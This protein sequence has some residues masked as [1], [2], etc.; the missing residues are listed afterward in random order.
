VRSWVIAEPLEA[1]M[2]DW[3]AFLVGLVAA[4]TLAAAPV[5]ADDAAKSASSC[6]VTKS[7]DNWQP[8]D[9]T[10]VIVSTGPSHD[11]KVTF[12]GSC[13]HMRWS[14]LARVDAR[15][16]SGMCLSAGDTIVF[17]RGGVPG[18]FEAEERCVVKSVE[19]VESKP[20]TPAVS[21]AN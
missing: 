15:V 8:V 13:L 21:P 3:T 12:M 20:Q 10:S 11:Y 18:R 4:C 17:G 9:K 14:V 1:N 2:R 16:S 7:I 19:R 5:A 6:A